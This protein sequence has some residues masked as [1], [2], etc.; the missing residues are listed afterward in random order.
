MAVEKDLQECKV[1]SSQMERNNEKGQERI[2]FSQN[3][4]DKNVVKWLL[5]ILYMMW[6]LAKCMPYV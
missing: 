5:N 6:T 4:N 2:R 1:G 3:M